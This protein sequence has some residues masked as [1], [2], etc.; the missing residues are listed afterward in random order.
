MRTRRQFFRLSAT[1]LLA[2]VAERALRRQP[3]AQPPALPAPAAASHT[4]TPQTF[5]RVLAPAPIWLPLAQSGAPPATPTPAIAQATGPSQIYLPILRHN[6]GDADDPPI[7]G[8]PSGTAQQATDWLVPRAAGYTPDD[9]AT[10]VATYAELGDQVGSDWFLALA[11]LAHETGHLTSW[12]SQRPRRNP[13]GIGVTGAVRPGTPDA[14]PGAGWTW[15]GTQ[16]RE[17]LSFAS[18]LDDA[19]PAHLG[20]LLAYALTDQQAND[21][22]RALIERALAYRPLADSYRGIAPTILGLNGR[23]AVPGTRYGQS[24]VVLARRMRQSV[25][26]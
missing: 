13:A 15:D 26:S 2:V 24:I 8:R 6:L 5:A 3:A 12:W 18:W 11:Q 10:I 25:A 22:Q 19:I 23:W 21:P 20:R 4:E 14:P 17:G 16:W 7:L 1:A 9:I